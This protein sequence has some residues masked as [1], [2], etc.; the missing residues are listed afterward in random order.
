MDWMKWSP[1]KGKRR[2]GEGS[3]AQR[4]K[5]NEGRRRSSTERERGRGKDSS[6]HPTVWIASSLLEFHPWVGIA[7]T[8]RSR[9]KLS[10]L[11]ISMK[12]YVIEEV[13][14]PP[15]HSEN[16]CRLI[17]FSRDKDG[18][19]AKI[20][21]TQHFRRVGKEK[22]NEERER[23]RDDNRLSPIAL[24]L[25]ISDRIWDGRGKEWEWASHPFHACSSL[26]LRRDEF[27]EGRWKEVRKEENDHGRLLVSFFPD[28][29]VVKDEVKGGG[30]YATLDVSPSMSPCLSQQRS[31]PDYAT[32][33]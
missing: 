30:W 24:L 11:R 9:L 5:E 2:E 3:N 15:T 23:E 20:A 7:S 27:R 26:I 25:F 6:F 14:L 22:G 12:S 10:R 8:L 28:V 16:E 1:S 19:R 13:L 33:F 31:N 29:N 4:S 32:T 21:D 18:N 17:K